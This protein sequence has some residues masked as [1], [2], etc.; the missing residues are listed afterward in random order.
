LTFLVLPLY[1]LPV[2]ASWIS[3]SEARK[4]LGGVSQQYVSRLF[5]EGLLVGERD[6]HGHLQ[7]DRTSVELLASE[8]VEKKRRKSAAAEEAKALRAEAADRFRRRRELEREEERERNSARDRL[9][10]RAVD[11]LETIARVLATGTNERP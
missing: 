2:V 3:T 10:M 9:Q 1:N 8:R 4:L 5:N 11:A 7:L 6:I